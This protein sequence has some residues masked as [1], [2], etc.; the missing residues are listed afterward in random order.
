MSDEEGNPNPNRG[1]KGCFVLDGRQHDDG[2]DQL[3]G[4]EHF[5][6]EALSDGAVSPQ[7]DVDRHGSGQGGR[8]STGR[9][10]STQYLCDDNDDATRGRDGSNKTEGE[11]DLEIKLSMS[12]PAG[13]ATSTEETYRRIEHSSTDTVEKPDVDG[14]RAAEAKG[15]EED[16]Q[17]IGRR[18]GITGGRGS[19]GDLGDGKGEEEEQEGAGELGDECGHVVPMDVGQKAHD[20][21]GMADMEEILEPHGGCI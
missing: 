19:V 12:F 4:G 9:G 3:H 15:D 8:D 10:N 21:T 5:D 11:G 7:A 6:E 2:E 20:R 17:N 16:D 14:D 13:H 18:V 1:E